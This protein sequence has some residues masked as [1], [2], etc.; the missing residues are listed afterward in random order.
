LI[1]V[2]NILGAAPVYEGFLRFPV[3]ILQCSLTYSVVVPNKKCFWHSVKTTV[4]LTLHSLSR[5]NKELNH[6]TNLDNTMSMVLR[7]AGIADGDASSC[8]SA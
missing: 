3:Y 8:L 7:E 4:N 5:Q 6:N 2:L 1:H